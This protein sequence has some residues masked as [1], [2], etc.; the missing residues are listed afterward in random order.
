MKSVRGIKGVGAESLDR[1]FEYGRVG[2]GSTDSARMPPL[3][4]N[5]ANLQGSESLTVST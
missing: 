1:D 2:L 3:I 5:E 4:R